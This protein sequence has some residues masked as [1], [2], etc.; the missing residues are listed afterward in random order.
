[1]ASRQVTRTGKAVGD[2]T[3]LCGDWGRSNKAEVIREIETEAHFYFVREVAPTAA[4]R[5]VTGH[6][7]KYLRSVADRRSRNNL[8]NLP[9]CA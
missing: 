1:M 7:G 5:V 6:N 2:I 4:V 3:A 9:D 8:G